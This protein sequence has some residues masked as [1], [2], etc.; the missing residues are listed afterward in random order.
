MYIVCLYVY[1]LYITLISMKVYKACC[2]WDAL[3][4]TSV[5]RCSVF[6]EAVYEA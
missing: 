4:C 2:S 6:E 5:G 1:N 3:E